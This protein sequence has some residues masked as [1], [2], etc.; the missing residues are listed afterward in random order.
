MSGW[1]S[2]V[3]YIHTMEYLATKKE[4]TTTDIYNNPDE[5]KMNFA[6]VTEANLEGL[7][8]S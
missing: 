8:S 4:K 2:K 3:R 6:E 7:H 5:S 1:I